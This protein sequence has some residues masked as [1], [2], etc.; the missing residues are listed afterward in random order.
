MA[1]QGRQTNPAPPITIKISDP[2]AITSQ[3]HFCQ[4]VDV[5][6]QPP[7]KFRIIIPDIMQ[8]SK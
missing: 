2:N 3:K 7:L 8:K 1:N 5:S 6:A 4:P